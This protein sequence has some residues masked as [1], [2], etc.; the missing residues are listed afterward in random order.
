MGFQVH[1]CP[2]CNV[3]WRPLTPIMSPSYSMLHAVCNF[4][5]KNADK[6]KRCQ[7]SHRLGEYFQEVADELESQGRDDIMIAEGKIN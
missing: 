3:Y 7:H 6:N 5:D 4:I 2:I 1:L